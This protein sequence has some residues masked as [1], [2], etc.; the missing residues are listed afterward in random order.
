MV[1]QAQQPV[2]GVQ[3]EP[4][5]LRKFADMLRAEAKTITDLNAGAEFGNAV[6]ALP[7]TDFGGAAQQAKDAVEK[8]VGRIGDRFT[9]LAE[10]LHTAAGAYELTQDDFTAKLK[11]IGLQ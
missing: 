11:T 7:G 5:A 4:D 1:E 6:N 10:S 9:T 3:V 8:C 2:T